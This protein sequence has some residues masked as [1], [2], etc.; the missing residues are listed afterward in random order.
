MSSQA[1]TGFDP[2]Q[3]D[4]FH[5][6]GVDVDQGPN[7]LLL[8]LR[9]SLDELE[10]EERVQISIPDGGPQA[11]DDTIAA[12]ARLVFLLAGVSYYKAAAPMRIVV[13][14]GLTADERSLL[15]A[16]YRSGLGEYSYRNQLPLD[17]VTI[18]AADR[19]PAAPTAPA[20][21]APGR[22]LVPFGGG[23]DS[24]VTVEGLRQITP[25]LALFVV[26]REG[27][28]FDAIEQAAEATGL[29]VLRAE[30]ALDP[31]ILRSGELG[32]RNGHVPITGIISAISV[33]AA[34]LADRDAVA[35]SNEESAS[36]GNLEWNGRIINHQWSK[37][38]EFEDLFRAAL[39]TSVPDAP[40][41]FSWLRPRSE[42]WVAER[43]AALDRYHPVFRSCNRAFHQDPDQR[44]D[45]WCGR[46]DKCAFVD[47]VLSPFMSADALRSVFAGHEPLDDPTLEGTFRT[48][49]GLGE[50]T[51]PWECVGDIDECRTALALTADRADRRDAPLVQRLARE[52]SGITDPQRLLRPLGP[53]RIPDRYAPP[54]LLG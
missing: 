48:L 18:E 35:M 43:F 49:L 40:D 16:T 10:F 7:Q 2:A 11:D 37:T 36:S 41:Y 25:D 31:M 21:S 50:D 52:M 22:P 33:L 42:L 54:D 34:L 26:S 1:P 28:R 4:A 44:L 6:V 27:H 29:P 14:S 53:H 30:R 17:S 32:F 51:K 12:G 8:R 45:H 3:V 46:C 20:L 38:L 39:R 23:I 9:Y 5:Y 19:T 15:D 13:P 24:I 47:L